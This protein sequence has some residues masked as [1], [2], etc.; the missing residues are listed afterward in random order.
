M[1]TIINTGLMRAMSHGDYASAKGEFVELIV[2]DVK[3]H[4]SW[5]GEGI[6]GNFIEAQAEFDEPMLRFSV[7]KRVERKWV[8]V[9]NASFCTELSA[10]VSADILGVAANHVMKTVYSDV[11]LNY[12]IRRMCQ[13]LSRM[14]EYKFRP[15]YAAAK[16]LPAAIYA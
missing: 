2:N 6:S 1:T 3:V 12:P 16:N 15:A 7:F 10:K 8:A 13:K 11:V 5:V 14:D 9:E 4:L